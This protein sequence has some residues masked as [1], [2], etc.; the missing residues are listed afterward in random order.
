MIGLKKILT[1][2]NRQDINTKFDECMDEMFVRVNGFHEEMKCIADSDEDN[3]KIQ[4][5]AFNLMRDMDFVVENAKL[6]ENEIRWSMLDIRLDKNEE[7]KNR[8]ANDIVEFRHQVNDIISNGGIGMDIKEVQQSHEVAIV[9]DTNAISKQLA[10]MCVVIFSQIMQD[11][12]YLDRMFAELVALN[13]SRTDDDYAEIFERTLERYESTEEFRA[14][15][16][17]YVERTINLCF[18]GKLVNPA[19]ISCLIKTRDTHAFYDDEIGEIWSSA[20]DNPSM[21]AKYLIERKLS[22][23]RIIRKFMHLYAEIGLLNEWKIEAN[24]YTFKIGKDSVQSKHLEFIAPYSEIRLENVWNDIHI[25]MDDAEAKD[26]EW[27]ALYHAL[28]VKHR[29]NNVDFWT[30]KKWIQCKFGEE[31][32][33]KENYQKYKQNYFVVTNQEEWDLEDYRTYYTSKKDNNKRGSSF[34]DKQYHIYNRIID[35]IYKPLQRVLAN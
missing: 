2:D 1:T 29:I 12:V 18:D 4:I 14:Y 17:H 10:G 22:N 32:I 20:S 30:F 7:Y 25:V 3:D 8:M 11:V 13:V 34:G 35:T 24:K 9:S 15:K 19:Q 6:Y 27:C 23:D 31:I 16:K 33:T 21:A 28:S 26:W 5:L